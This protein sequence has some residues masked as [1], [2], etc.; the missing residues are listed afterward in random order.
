MRLMV[1]ASILLAACADADRAAGEPSAIELAGHLE[2]KSLREA[3]GLAHSGIREDLLWAINDD[4]PT[5]LYALGLSGKK[6][7]K[8]RIENAANRD[9][10]DLASFVLDGTPYL[11]VADI[12]DNN[13]RRKDV[14]LY[15]VEEPDPADDE[16][17]VAWEIEFTY[18]E[19]PRDAEALAVDVAAGRILVLSKRDIPARLY[20]LPLQPE[21]KDRITAKFIGAV[22]SLP[23]PSRRDVNNALANKDWHWQPTGMDIAAAHDAVLILTYRGIYYY[24]RQDGEA[25]ADALG[26]APL[27]ASLGAY[28]NAESIA[29]A[30]SGDHA[31]VIT[32]KQHA[33]L[34]RID[35]AAAIDAARTPR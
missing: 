16:V 19:G 15:I 28:R 24:A 14:T 13:A 29:F 3:S 20:A 23:Q 25:W 26:R 17:E 18:P 32:E 35:L 10:E 34:L 22:S 6:R 21:T 12:G 31:F 9:W 7:G 4:G 33:P 11:V 27:G 2:S 8:V 5:D 30:Q 1:C